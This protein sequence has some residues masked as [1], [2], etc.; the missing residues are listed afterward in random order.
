MS[1]QYVL[2]TDEKQKQ[3]SFVQFVFDEMTVIGPDIPF[4]SWVNILFSL[5]ADVKVLDMCASLP[6][7]PLD[8]VRALSLI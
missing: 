2:P 7:F 4:F 8:V 1:V 3:G 5:L 6:S